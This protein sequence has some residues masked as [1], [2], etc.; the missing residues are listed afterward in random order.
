MRLAH[1]ALSSGPAALSCRTVPTSTA[2]DPAAGPCPCGLPAGYDECCGRFHRGAA[3][4]PTA[5]ALMRSRYSAFAVGDAAYLRDTWDPATRPRH[6]DADPD[7]R[8]TGLT[9]L[10]RTGGE[11]LAAEGTVRFRARHDGG[12]VEEDS[13]FRRHQGRWLYVG[14]VG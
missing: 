1:D 8:W 7:V 4:A 12:A 5:E 13:R 3:A 6:V 10:A 9:V 11:L 14:P 2:P